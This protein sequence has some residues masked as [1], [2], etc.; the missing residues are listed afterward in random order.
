M[1]LIDTITMNDLFVPVDEEYK[2]GIFTAIAK[3]ET[4]PFDS[5]E[6]LIIDREYYLS[7]SGDKDISK[8]FERMRKLEED[9]MISSALDS[10]AEICS[11]K[12]S[13][14]WNRLWLAITT[15]YNPLENY[16]MKQT[17]TPDITHETT[18]NV[19]TDVTTTT[20]KDTDT[21]VTRST[22]MNVSTETDDDITDNGIYGF[23]SS[24][25]V[26]HDK[27]TRNG[28]VIVSG[29]DEDN[30]ET[31]HT[32]GDADDNKETQRVTGDSDKNEEH[33]TSTETGT[34]DLERSGNIGV[35]TSQQMLL[36][37]I[38]VRTRFNF[39]T[40]IMNDVDSILCKLVY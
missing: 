10:I 35:T 34:R 33:V 31:V 17:E 24:S 4:V 11:Q 21:T 12:F 25:P 5:S 39:M 16:N 13:L 26:P 1:K 40:Q 18:K 6:S 23:N 7:H 2:G 22:N 37:E 27:S 38:D 32:L 36:S 29:S 28:T 9:E 8:F 19:A 20:G 30:V 14:N 3:L 15:E